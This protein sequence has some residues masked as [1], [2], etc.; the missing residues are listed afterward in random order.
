MK[1]ILFFALT[2]TSFFHFTDDSVVEWKTP[3]EHDFGD[4]EQGKPVYVDFTFKNT[5]KEPF[6]IDNVRTTCGC[7]AGEWSYEPILPD[8]TSTITIEYD[9]EK[10]GYFRKKITIF[11]SNQKKAEKLYIE[12]YVEFL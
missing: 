5:S 1:Y 4:I 11:F 9:A 7:T 2:L 6:V 3:M 8:S 12:G 10:E